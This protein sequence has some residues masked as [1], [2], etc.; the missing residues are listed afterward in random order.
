MRL[1]F[2]DDLLAREE[3]RC[4]GEVDFRGV[5]RKAMSETEVLLQDQGSWTQAVY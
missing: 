3:E 5:L 1:W 4:C 2:H